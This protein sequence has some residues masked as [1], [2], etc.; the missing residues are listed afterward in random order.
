M[1]IVH[2]SSISQRH[3]NSAQ[4]LGPSEVVHPG[5]GLIP[6]E[7]DLEDMKLKV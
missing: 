7:M 2:G 4:I 5:S 3:P 6:K 1:Q